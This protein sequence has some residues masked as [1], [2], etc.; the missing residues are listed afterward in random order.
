MPTLC[1]N[2]ACRAH[3]VYGYAK[4]RPLYCSEH[5]VQGSANTKFIIEPLPVP[6]N[7]TM[8]SCSHPPASNKYKGLCKDCYVRM[9]PDDPLSLQ[10]VYKS[11]ATV[12]QK[13]IDSKFD[14]FI[15]GSG[16]S[17]ICIN[18]K[19]VRVVYSS[20]YVASPSSSVIVI[21]FHPGKYTNADGTTSNPQLYTRLPGLEQQIA[22][23]MEQLV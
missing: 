12:I 14:G 21:M 11:K 23:K 10:T 22:E 1:K 6:P 19:T 7:I 8:Q 13:F 16:F 18:G 3:A 17:D 5:R 9:Y 15:H 2:Q 4:G 20:S